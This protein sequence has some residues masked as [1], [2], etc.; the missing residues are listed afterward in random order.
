MN[1]NDTYM[2]SLYLNLF[3]QGRP[4]DGL[5]KMSVR[6]VRKTDTHLGHSE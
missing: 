2:T 1:K 3:W 5:V 4:V 6:K